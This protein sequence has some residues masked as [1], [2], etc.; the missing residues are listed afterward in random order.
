MIKYLLEFQD[1]NQSGVLMSS[2]THTQTYSLEF[3]MKF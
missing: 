2:H 1:T 3:P